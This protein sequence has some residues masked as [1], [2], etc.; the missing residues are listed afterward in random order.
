MAIVINGSGT[1]TGISVG[2]LPDGI[3]DAGTLATDSVD[4]AEL[5]DGA[6]D[7]SHL[8]SDTLSTP[9][10]SAILSGDFTLANASWTK[11]TF[12]SEQ[13]DTDSAFASNKFTVPAGE[14]G[15]YFFI[16]NMGLSQIDDAKM[17]VIK[18]YK[19]GSEDA[20]SYIKMQGSHTG[21][22][23]NTTSAILDLSATDYVEAYAY[24]NCGGNETV[25]SGKSRFQGFKL[26]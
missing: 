15:K 18:F 7:N 17:F 5:I 26:T 6:V 19:N 4:S 10:F 3:V 22:I 16:T 25:Q 12:D 2:G 1:V 23:N 13:W 9:S 21:S 24:Q 20:Y 8:A 14:G 11:I